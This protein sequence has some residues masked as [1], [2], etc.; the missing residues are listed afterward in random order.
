MIERDKIMQLV[1]QSLENS[2]KF[3]V[4]IRIKPDNKI[5]VFLDSDGQ[6]TIDDCIQTSKYIDKHLNRDIEDYELIVSSAGIDQP[7][8]LLRQYKK[9]IGRPVCVTLIDTTKITGILM[10]ADNEHIA[11]KPDRDKKLKK[12]DEEPLR[13]IPFDLIKETKGIVTFKK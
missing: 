5:H 12:K 11:L 7:Y 1:E 6:I 9:N 8:K 10:E 3:I 13:P 2:D 4:E